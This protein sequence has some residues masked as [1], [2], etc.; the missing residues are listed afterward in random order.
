MKSFKTIRLLFHVF[1]FSSLSPSL[2]ARLRGMFRCKT[3]FIFHNSRWVIQ[4]FYCCPGKSADLFL[5]SPFEWKTYPVLKV[6][7]SEI[8]SRKTPQFDDK[9]AYRKHPRNQEHIMGTTFVTQVPPENLS[10]IKSCTA[11]GGVTFM[12][13]QRNI[14]SFH[15]SKKNKNAN[16]TVLYLNT[17]ETF[18]IN[19]KTHL[20]SSQS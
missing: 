20:H 17:I 11:C 12:N 9:D 7:R 15:R 4:R 5:S 10:A 8:N 14:T 3:Y 18:I 1:F 19:I 6:L 13:T 16:S 2:G